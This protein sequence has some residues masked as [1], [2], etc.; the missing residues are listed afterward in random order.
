MKAGAI[1][2]AKRSKT[3]LILLGVGYN[4][5]RVLKSWDKFEIPK[6]FSTANAVYSNPVY[7][8]SDLSFADTSEIINN[9]EQKLN[10]VQADANNFGN[11]E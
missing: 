7:I 8:N 2:T 1:I 11:N 4:K 5:K 10:E 3:P 9:C 6:L